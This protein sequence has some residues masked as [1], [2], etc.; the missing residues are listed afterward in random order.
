MSFRICS[1]VL[2]N[3]N[4]IAIQSY[5]FNIQRILGSVKTV[6]SFLDEYEVDEIHLIIPLKGEASNT[7]PLLRALQDISISTPLSIGGGLTSNNI[8]KITNDPYFERLI[9]NSLIFDDE[10]VIKQ[11]SLKMGHQAIVGYIPFILQK[12]IRKKKCHL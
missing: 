6:L 1:T 2:M 3:T 9:F 7:F 12:N 8:A 4:G 11:V 5:G 10:Q